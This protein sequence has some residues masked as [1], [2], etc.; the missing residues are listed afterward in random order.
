VVL[1]SHSPVF[2]W[3]PVWA[4]GFLM[5][6]VTFGNGYQVAFVPPGTEAQ[7]QVLKSRT[8]PWITPAA[9][10]VSLVCL[11]IALSRVSVL[12]H[13]R[14]WWTHSGQYQADKR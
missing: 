12:A 3:W 10:V 13:A 8:L 4:V 14:S 7:T 1:I 9:V 11:W 5:A 6:A 2:Y